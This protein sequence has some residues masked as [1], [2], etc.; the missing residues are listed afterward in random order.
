MAPEILALLFLGCA[1]YCQSS[2][3]ISPLPSITI[4]A[5]RYPNTTS[6][7]S[8][9]SVGALPSGT[10]S[11]LVASSSTSTSTITGT[12]I[13]P[14]GNFSSNLHNISL[15]PNGVLPDGSASVPHEP[16]PLSVGSIS[17]TLVTST[18]TSAPSD[19]STEAATNTAWQG[20]TWVTTEKNGKPTIVPVIVGCPDCGGDDG[21]IILWNLPEIPYVEFQFPGF[22]KLPKFHLPCLKIFGITL[23]GS[24]NTPP[25]DDSEYSP[26]RENP[27]SQS[28]SKPSQAQVTQSS[29]SATASSRTSTTASPTSC[30]SQTVSDCLIACSTA[31]TN[32]S[33]CSTTCSNTIT[34][35]RTS[36]ITTTSMVSTATP[37]TLSSQYLIYPIDNVSQDQ[38]DNLATVLFSNLGAGNVTQIPLGGNDSI[39]VAVMNS[40]MAMSLRENPTVSFSSI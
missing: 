15:G 10:S 7:A 5:V 19:F 22:P 12:S 13:I 36:G 38:I 33:C 32:T 27:P 31:N 34:A 21:G 6:N 25:V 18:L 2:N 35:C 40:S 1:I 9:T 20:N 26:P 4:G 23:S 11:I 3:K 30:S 39:F 24:C 28:E 29:L 17:S 14:V 37:T 8:N 16:T